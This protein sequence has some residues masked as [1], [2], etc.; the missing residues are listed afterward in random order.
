MRKPTKETISILILLIVLISF[1]VFYSYAGREQIPNDSLSMEYEN[2]KEKNSKII[3][4]HVS[5]FYNEPILL[6]ISAPT[7]EIYFT[8]D[9]SEPDRNATR[10][11]KPFTIFDV[12]ENPNLYSARTD[13]SPG[14]WQ[15]NTDGYMGTCVPTE[16]VDKC[17]ILRA[18]CYDALGEKIGE[19]TGTYFIGYQDKAGYDNLKI[20]SIITPPENLFGYENGIYILGK[21]FDEEYIEGDGSYGGK[22]WNYPGNYGNRGK[23]WERK[24]DIQLFDETHQLALS[25]KAGIRIHGYTSRGM[26]PKSLN[27]YARNEYDGNDFLYY[28]FF[29]EEEN[30]KRITL[31][32][33]GADYY[34]LCRDRLVAELSEGLDFT[35][36]NFE[37]CAMFLDGEYWGLYYVTEKYDKQMLHERYGVAQNNIV[38]I[39]NGEVE[40]GVEND[41]HLY[42]EMIDFFRNMDLSIEENYAQAQTYLDLESLIDY[43]A[44]EIYIGRHTD[45]L[46]DNYALWRTRLPDTGGGIAMVDGD[47][48][49][50]TSTPGAWIIPESIALLRRV[51]QARSFMPYVKMRIFG[52]LL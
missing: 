18:V 20:L 12:S 27:L 24:A 13:I 44:M 19:E 48:C 14:L 49:F 51:R 17:T 21:T 8:L 28:R 50:L 6:S 31:F 42:E 22:W 7:K 26:N 32:S 52:K 4:S 16:P 30:L 43:F 40:V 11:T 45:W 3:F 36:M 10:Y 15:E 5:G 39:K 41:I 47:G 2:N 25:Q 9:G 33:G 37:P 1:A 46:T 35:T 34:S 23:E 29:E 38:M